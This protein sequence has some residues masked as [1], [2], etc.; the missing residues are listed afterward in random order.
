M[1]NRLAHVRDWSVLVDWD[2]DGQYAHALSDVSEAW[3]SASYEYGTARRSNPQRPTIAPGRGQIALI[4][5][6]FVPARST[7][8]SAM[9]LE[10]RHRIRATLGADVLWECW[11]QEANHRAGSSRAGFTTRFR[12]EGLLE[13]PGRNPVSISQ[14]EEPINADVAAITALAQTAYGIDAADYSANIAPT[15][16]GIYGFN[17]PAARYISEFSQVSGALPLAGP[18]GEL[19]LIDPSRAPVAPSTNIHAN[20]YMIT[21]AT[22]EFDAEQLWTVAEARAVTEGIDDANG[23]QANWTLGQGTADPAVRTF[24]FDIP[25]PPTGASLTDFKAEGIFRGANYR[26]TLSGGGSTT[27]TAYVSSEPTIAVTFTNTAIAG[28]RQADKRHS[29]D[30]RIVD[31]IR[32]KPV[33]VADGWMVEHHGE[34]TGR[35]PGA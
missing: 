5:E 12:L 22:T 23:R 20:D 35:Y 19:H 31:A 7:V 3:A 26:Y 30:H 2:N 13:R 25:A 29:D 24:S 15:P 18:A 27:H 34:R 4:G 6:E 32:S 21:N 28:R 11:I 16:L 14:L 17:G 9:Q 10:L 8:L 1:A 33:L